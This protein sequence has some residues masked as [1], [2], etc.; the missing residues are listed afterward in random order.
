MTDG[1]LIVL[2]VG[3]FLLVALPAGEA[4]GAAQRALTDA[5]EVRPGAT[6]VEVATLADQVATWLGS[7]T[8]D[9]DIWVRVEGS[10]DDPRTV[11]FEMGRGDRRLAHRL[12][13][14]GPALCE[15]L[16][17][18]L[19]LA[20]ALAIRVSVLDDIV[21]AREPLEPTATR[22]L[23]ERDRWALGGGVAGAFGVL[24]GASVGAA[25]R[26]ERELPPNFVLR[27]GMLGLAAWDETFAAV[28]GSFDAQAVAGRLDACVEA[29]VVPRLV[30][31]G[32]AGV[33][34]GGLFSQGQSFASSRSA[35]SGWTAAAGA[36][37][38]MARI[39]DHWSVDVE[40]SVILPLENTRV[41]V[42]DSTGEE[43]ASRDLSGRGVMMT[44]GPTYRF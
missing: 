19:G 39:S 10:P 2:M 21:P 30:A 38:A 9:E 31:R 28:S 42:L 11:S 6:C 7:G 27:L 18:A 3:A 23:D 13:D 20:I 1:P 26:L 34:V 14:P 5:I 15:H 41:R 24:P 33:L 17:A 37:E 12:F 36:L 25:V 29:D 40:A 32:C 43:V 8:A 35:S 22:K 44:V 4:F 16:Q